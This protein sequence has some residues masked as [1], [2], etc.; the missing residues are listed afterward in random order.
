[1]Q[2]CINNA[3]S[4]AVG[5][6][7]CLSTAAQAA[8]LPTVQQAKRLACAVVADSLQ[9]AIDQSNEQ[10]AAES[11]DALNAAELALVAVDHISR[12]QWGFDVF[13]V[14]WLRAN[15]VARLALEAFPDK[16]SVA[17]IHLRTAVREF[18]C[19]YNAMSFLDAKELEHEAQAGGAA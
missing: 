11:G 17:W 10:W 8:L 16:G 12:D 3:A 19:L 15:S 1:M 4:E 6:A 18:E 2:E 9:R 7:A 14:D 5:A 13:G